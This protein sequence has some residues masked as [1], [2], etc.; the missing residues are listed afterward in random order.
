MHLRWL[1]VPGVA[2][3]L[4]A[5]CGSSSG[6][7]TASGTFDGHAVSK[8]AAEICAPE[9]AKDLQ[10]DLVQKTSSTPKPGWSN[11]DYTCSYQ[12]AHGASFL[13]S[14]RDLGTEPKAAA[15]LWP[16]AHPR[17]EPDADRVRHAG[18]VPH[19]QRQLG[20]AEGQ[21]RADRRRAGPAQVLVEPA[22]HPGR[23]VRGHRRRHHGLLEGR[24]PRGH[25][26]LPVAR[27][28]PAVQQILHENRV[29]VRMWSSG[30]DR[31]GGLGG[32]R[33]RLWRRRGRG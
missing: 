5:A 15:Y 14:V 10:A 3:L 21:P 13:L 30:D 11:G 4:L 32:R 29:P 17:Q 22:H 6:N 27:R 33:P 2:L 1:V 18:C 9:A 23:C 8:Q 19:D 12:Y 25:E 31:D 7:M 16:R 20:G 26:D 24:L 28:G